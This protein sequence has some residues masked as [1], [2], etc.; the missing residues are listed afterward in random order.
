M[1]CH[2][3]ITLNFMLCAV[4]TFT[5]QTFLMVKTSF[6]TFPCD[7][8]SKPS[9][10]S[11]PTPQQGPLGRIVYHRNNSLVTHEAYSHPLP[12][13]T[14]INKRTDTRLPHIRNM[15]TFVEHKQQVCTQS[16]CAH[17]ITTLR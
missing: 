1:T 15:C 8:R 10:Y 14:R 16:F 13:M 12:S 7:V 9:L 2:K 6:I 4:D 11:S 3:H 5:C 17:G